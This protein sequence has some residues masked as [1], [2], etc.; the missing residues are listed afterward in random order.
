MLF[1]YSS[2]SAVAH[3]LDAE[4]HNVLRLD[5]TRTSF[6][7]YIIRF[8]GYLPSCLQSIVRRRIPHYFLPNTVILKTLKPDWDDEFDNEK[9][10][11]KRLKSL[12]GDV[13]PVYLGDAIYNHTPSILISYVDGVMPH[14]QDKHSPMPAEEF[15]SKVELAI[16]KMEPFGVCHGDMKLDNFIISG[17]C[18]VVID[19]ESVEDEPEEVMDYAIVTQL[20]M[21]FKRYQ[22]YLE[23]RFDP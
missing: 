3:L 17:D 18:I 9:T 8:I 22:I 14:E 15:Q 12:Q 16:R 21:L 5:L 7:K 2:F 10:M 11:Y 4:H 20:K 6:Q 19:L 23:N 1:G 13:I